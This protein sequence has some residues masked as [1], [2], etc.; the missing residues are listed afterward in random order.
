MLQF[1]GSVLL[2]QGDRVSE[3]VFYA[4]NKDMRKDDPRQY[5]T[6]VMH[7]CT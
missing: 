6:Y 5:C 1:M 2:F 3:S 7:G 4:G